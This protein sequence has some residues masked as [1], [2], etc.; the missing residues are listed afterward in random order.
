MLSVLT[1]AVHPINRDLIYQVILTTVVRAVQMGMGGVNKII[2]I[3]I[4]GTA[5]VEIMVIPT[6]DIVV[7]EVA[8]DPEEITPGDFS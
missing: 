3:V 7:L 8:E 4:K 1:L 5:I 2:V 6:T